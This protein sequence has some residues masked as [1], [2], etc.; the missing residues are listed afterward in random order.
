MPC[1]LL[2]VIVVAG[3]LGATA[4]TQSS[5]QAAPNPISGSP[6]AQPIDGNLLRHVQRGMTKGQVRNL[7]GPPATENTYWTW[8]SWMPGAFNDSLRT[9]WRYEG[10]GTVTFTEPKFSGLPAIVRAVDIETASR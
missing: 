9:S 6:N 7:V 10:M 1:R 2:L 8:L 4:C 5:K 3:M